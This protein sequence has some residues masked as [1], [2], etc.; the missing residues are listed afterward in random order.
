[1]TSLGAMSTLYACATTRG[2]NDGAADAEGGA[3]GGLWK[4]IL[5]NRDENEHQSRPT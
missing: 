5:C 1:M 4:V 3:L 2:R